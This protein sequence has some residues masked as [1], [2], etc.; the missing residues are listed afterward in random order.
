MSA[1]CCARSGEPWDAR[2]LKALPVSGP[3]HRVGPC[4]RRAT[5]TSSRKNSQS[6][7]VPPPR[8]ET[9]AIG[10]GARARS[11]RPF[12]RRGRNRGRGDAGD[13]PRALREVLVGGEFH[14]ASDRTSRWHADIGPTS[15]Y[16]WPLIVGHGRPRIPLIAG[17]DRSSIPDSRD[18]NAGWRAQRRG[19]PVAGMSAGQDAVERAPPIEWRTAISQSNG[20]SAARN[21]GTLFRATS[22]SSSASIV[23]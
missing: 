18:W 5:A 14:P 19:P 9:L 4:A 20:R 1:L 22:H 16:A 15:A 13:P 10:P 8:E 2:Q 12:S 23:Q 11:R 17:A 21:S 6:V 7:C 3:V